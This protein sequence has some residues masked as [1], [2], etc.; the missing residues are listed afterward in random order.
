MKIMETKVKTVD[1]VNAAQV[2]VRTFRSEGYREDNIYVL[3]YDKDRTERV[4]ERASAG[5][6]GVPEEGLGTAIANIF[7]S[8]GDELRAKMRS[9]GFTES[10]AERLEAEMENDKIVVIAWGGT[11]YGGDDYDPAIYY[12]PPMMH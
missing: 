11:Q 10:D 2:Q 1:N 7:R 6:I 3:A 8:R 4:A 12:Y 5:Q 9:M